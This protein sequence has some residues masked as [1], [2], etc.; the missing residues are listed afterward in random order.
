MPWKSIYGNRNTERFI[1]VLLQRAFYWMQWLWVDWVV[2]VVFLIRSSEFYK[3]PILPTRVDVFLKESHSVVF[4]HHSFL[5]AQSVGCFSIALW[6]CGVGIL[7]VRLV[8]RSIIWGKYVHLH[9]VCTNGLVFQPYWVGCAIVITLATKSFAP[10]VQP[11]KIR[12]T[13]TMPCRMPVCTAHLPSGSEHGIKSS[14]RGFPSHCVSLL[15][16]LAN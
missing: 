4:C 8:L 5:A 15:P 13:N 3:H 7:P 11:N 6:H 10:H 1:L 9:A 16:P 2:L 12:S 14:R